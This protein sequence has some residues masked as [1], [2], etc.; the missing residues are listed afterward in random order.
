MALREIAETVGKWI[1]RAGEKPRP[2]VQRRAA[3]P[4]PRKPETPAVFND[5]IRGI[6]KSKTQAAASKL[7]LISLDKIRELVPDSGPDFTEKARAAVSQVISQRLGPKD[8]FTQTGAD[9]Y[10]IVF[11]SLSQEEAELQCVLIVQEILRT[12][13]DDRRLDDKVDIRT[14]TVGLDGNVGMEE[15]DLLDVIS[16]LMSKKPEVRVNAAVPVSAPPRQSRAAARAE[17]RGEYADGTEALP[18]DLFFSYQPLWDVKR[19]VISTYACAVMDGKSAGYDVLGHDPDR[20]LIPALD[21]FVLGRVTAELRR[22]NE[23]GKRLLVSCP[24]H[25]STLCSA[26]SWPTYQALCDRLAMLPHRDIVFEI[27]GAT[28]DE[29][30]LLLLAHGMGKIVKYCHHATLRTGDKIPDF[31]FS[32]DCK[33]RYFSLDIDTLSGSEKRKM[34]MMDE[35]VVAARKFEM[36]AI[37]YGLKSLS[38]VTAAVGSGFVCIGGDGVHAAI[39]KP[40]FIFRFEAKNLLDHLGGASAA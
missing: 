36:G 37:L 25:I 1:F 12:L 24:V 34:K 13:F 20:F 7:Q 19:K 28:A 26:K 16:R 11:D 31:V 27:H 40:D 22:L 30:G 18:P 38:Q 3:P 8:A 17:N 23:E 21:F 14:V 5:S 15:V 4:A 32:P 29:Q 6:L 9:S 10:M 39:E 2:D 33:P 35:Y